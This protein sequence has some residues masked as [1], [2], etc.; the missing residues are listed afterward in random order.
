M[1]RKNLDIEWLKLSE[2]A[3]AYSISVPELF[4]ACLRG[5]IE[6]AHLIKP[7]KRKGVRL[8]NKR[9]IDEYIRSHLP[10]GSRYYQRPTAEA[11]TV[12]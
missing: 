4:R 1:N 5:D 7:G 8:I 3:V 12:E 11:V 10:G 6:S 2:A 9:S